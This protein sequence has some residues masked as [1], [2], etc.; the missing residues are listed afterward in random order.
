MGQQQPNERRDP[1]QGQRQQDQQKQQDRP[2]RDNPRD[3]RQPQN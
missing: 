3:D 1:G 2:Q